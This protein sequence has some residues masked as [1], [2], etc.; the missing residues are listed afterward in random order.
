[1]TV[2]GNREPTD[3]LFT[4]TFPIVTRVVNAYHLLD[5]IK[6]S[7]L[8]KGS[9]K[10]CDSLPIVWRVVCSAAVALVRAAVRQTTSMSA[11]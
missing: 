5:E 6:V 1:M 4:L 2:T 8:F 7:F 11:V 10:S 9:L 3:F